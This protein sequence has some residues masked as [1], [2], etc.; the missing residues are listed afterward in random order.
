MKRPLLKFEL[1][2]LSIGGK[3]YLLLPKLVPSQMEILADRLSKT[4][5]AVERGPVLTAKRRGH[6]IRVSPA[7]LCWSNRDPS[8]AVG[9]AIPDLLEV[10]KV[11]VSLGELARLY[12]RMR[13]AGSR[14]YFHFTP[15]VESGPTWVSL[16]RAGAS[17][18]SPDERSVIRAAVG[19]FEGRCEVLTDFP[20]DGS[21]ARLIGRR[22][23]YASALTG[24]ELSS[25]L[26]AVGVS[27][28]RNSYIPENASIALERPISTQESLREA[29]R[30]LGEWCYFDL[31]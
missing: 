27:A 18:L 26:R 3:E 14:S 30:G 12:F 29:M 13:R 8:D 22:L 11:P 23:Y 10:R 5:F 15:R 24:P 21:R 1:V 2:G 25:T 31:L 19:S 16:R 20:L 6:V 7:G 28:A 17:G 4:G 9:P